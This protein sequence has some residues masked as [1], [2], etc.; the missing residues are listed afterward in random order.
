MERTE[1]CFGKIQEDDRLDYW[2]P[3]K[4]SLAGAVLKHCFKVID[5]TIQKHA[6]VTFK[7][8]FT[9][10]PHT[11][12]YNRK[13]GYRNDAWENL[14]VLYVAC[15]SISPAFVEAALIQKYKGPWDYALYNTNLLLFF[16]L[17]PHF[18]IPYIYIYM[19]ESL[20]GNIWLKMVIYNNPALRSGQTGCHNI[21]DGGDTVPPGDS[22]LGPF[23]VYMVYRSFKRPSNAH[24]MLW[25]GKKYMREKQCWT[26]LP[27]ILLHTHTYNRHII[28]IISIY[29]ASSL[30]FSS[31]DSW[32][33]CYIPSKVEGPC[34][35]WEEQRETNEPWQIY[36][37]ISSNASDLYGR[38]VYLDHIYVCAC[39][40]NVCIYIYTCWTCRSYIYI[41]WF[42]SEVCNENIHI[43]ISDPLHQP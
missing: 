12:M 42:S 23:F 9:H 34:E 30:W 27:S 36:H 19:Y 14:L 24:L 28:H 11:R 21:R 17:H 29:R 25:D 32:P 18:W 13:F 4:G 37:Y 10:C 2:L 20:K 26:F 22:M 31:W 8:G 6:P 38:H 1:G 33:T 5:I 39:A 43:Y 7:L 41:V 16:L 40:P 15:E 3:K 35:H